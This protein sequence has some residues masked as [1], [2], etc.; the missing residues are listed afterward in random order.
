MPRGVPANGRRQPRAFPQPQLEEETPLAGIAVD[1]ADRVEAPAPGEDGPQDSS[2]E[3]TVELIMPE[4]ELTP[5]QLEIKALR[6]QLAKLS[7]KKDEEPVTEEITNPGDVDN[8]LIHFLEDGLTALGKVWYRGQ[9]LEFVPG[10][11][12]YKDT[13]NR[14]GH[15]WLELR[16]NDFAQ[17][18]RWGKVMFRP[19]PWPG[20]NYADGTFETLRLEKGEGKIPPP[21]EDEIARAEKARQQRAAPRLPQEV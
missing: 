13:F 21:S 15:S 6:D 2:D 7:G 17:V 8:I 19:G 3:L 18:E 12:A 14:R 11:R 20:K 9:E 4:V 10:S 1:E 5:E 16:H